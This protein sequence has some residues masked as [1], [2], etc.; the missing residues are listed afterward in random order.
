MPQYQ[1]SVG[2]HGWAV[3]MPAMEGLLCP[4]SVGAHGWAVGMP[5]M[6]GL[7]CPGTG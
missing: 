4:G 2:A 5:A 6:E 7:L 1:C 3:G